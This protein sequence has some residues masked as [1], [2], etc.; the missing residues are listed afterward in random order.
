MCLFFVTI[1]LIIHHIIELYCNVFHA[2]SQSCNFCCVYDPFF[3]KHRKK[4]PLCLSDI[5]SDILRLCL[6]INIFSP[7]LTVPVRKKGI[8]SVLLS[9]FANK[10][11]SKVERITF[12]NISRDSKNN[13]NYNFYVGTLSG[14]Q[15]LLYYFFF[16]FSMDISIQMSRNVMLIHS[17]FCLSLN[18]YKFIL[19]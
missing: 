14:R 4:N 2:F 5:F 1:S 19:M 13:A 3:L 11:N 18:F 8:T 17:S 12:D 6:T 16:F 10:E 15:S 7:T 9:S